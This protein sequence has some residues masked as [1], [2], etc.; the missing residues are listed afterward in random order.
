MLLLPLTHSLDS[1][2]CLHVIEH[3]G[4]GRYGDG[5]EPDGWI[6][7]LNK[8]QRVLAPGGQLLLL[9]PCGRRG[10]EFNAHRVFHPSRIVEKQD[11][12]DLI[13]FS[14]IPDNRA[15]ARIDNHS[16]DIEESVEYGCRLSR[17]VRE[18]R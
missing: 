11:K 15:T 4:L 10:V 18:L 12:L 5:V 9:T 6:S 3:I 2:S 1:L 16:L 7:G 8:L 17:F 14:F 13:E